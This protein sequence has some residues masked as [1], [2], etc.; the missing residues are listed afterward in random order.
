MSVASKARPVDSLVRLAI[1]IE[2]ERARFAPGDD[3]VVDFCCAGWAEKAR[4]IAVG[5]YWRKLDREMR[6][7][8]A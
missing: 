3:R 5:F 4:Q 8:I 7:G 1:K 6:E 2:S